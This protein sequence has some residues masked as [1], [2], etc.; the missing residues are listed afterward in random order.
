MILVVAA[1]A[2]Q[3][4][5]DLHAALPQVSGRADARL[6]Q[7]LRARQRAGA[8]EDGAGGAGT[9]H[10]SVPAP[11]DAGGLAA[12][13]EDALDLGLDLQHDVAACECGTQIGRGG[14]G[15]FAVLLR[16]LEVADAELRG[17]VEIVVVG[18]AALLRGL[19]EGSV[20]RMAVGHVDD[21]ERALSAVVAVGEPLVALRLAEIG[22]YVCVAPAG[23]AGR[24]P[25]VVVGGVA[26]DVDHPV[27]RARSAGHAP[28]RDVDP[29]AGRSRLGLRRIGPDPVGAEQADEGAGR[30]AVDDAFVR[31]GLQ[32]ED[33]QCRIFRQPVG[34]HRAGRTGADDDVVES[35]V[36]RAG[37]Q[38]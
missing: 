25:V 36:H 23:A 28:L 37:I 20:Q 33:A 21:R 27:D 8:E 38:L 7:N 30:A 18:V 15:A 9:S 2:R 1:D 31:A 29:P 13:E 19:D 32:H 34:D 24:R 5:H 35:L 16:H 10:P 14:A 4:V 22:Q 26:A 11:G 3:V 6:H 12:R 17:A